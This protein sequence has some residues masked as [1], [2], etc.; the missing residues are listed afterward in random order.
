MW[1]YQAWSPGSLGALQRGTQDP[2]PPSDG[3]RMRRPGLLGQRHWPRRTSEG[4]AG[5]RGGAGEEESHRWS[6]LQP[7]ARN[8]AQH[9]AS[10][11]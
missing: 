1:D 8:S 5:A 11:P 10:A 4:R 2:R 6:T 7:S 3:G 9:R